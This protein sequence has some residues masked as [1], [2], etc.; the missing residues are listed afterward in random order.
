MAFRRSAPKSYDVT[1]LGDRELSKKLARLNFKIQTSFIRKALKSGGKILLVE[2]KSR[3]HEKTGALRRGLKLQRLKKRFGSIG[4]QVVTPTRGKLD[5]APDA[6]GYYPAVL[7]YGSVNQP[8][9]SY[10]RAGTKMAE[11][12]VLAEV[13]RSLRSSVGSEIRKA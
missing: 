2:V 7:E 5:I 13:A 11:K 8:P 6:K 12:P 9:N 3:A 10:L 1:A 4:V